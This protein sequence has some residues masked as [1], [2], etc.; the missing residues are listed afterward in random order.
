MICPYCRQEN[1][2]VIDSRPSDGAIRRRRKCLNRFCQRR[3]TTYERIHSSLMVLK[4][5]GSCEPFDP[6]KIQ[7]GLEKA[8]GKRPIDA[9]QIEFIVEAVEN[10]VHQE[11]EVEVSTH[12][13]GER[14]IE[15]LREVDEVAFLRFASVYREFET[16]RDFQEEMECYHPTLPV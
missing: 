12:F 14:I 6:K 4:R 3:F 16:V 8:F 2:K 9:A 15:I 10:A 11:S 5:N 13:I 1:T 7:A